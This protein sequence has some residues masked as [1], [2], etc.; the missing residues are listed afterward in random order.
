MVTT[1]Q[2]LNVSE[3]LKKCGVTRLAKESSRFLLEYQSKAVI[4]FTIEDNE[5]FATLQDFEDRSKGRI[6]R[7]TQEAIKFCLSKDEYYVNAL[8]SKANGNAPPRFVIGQ[9]S[10]TTDQ[11]YEENSEQTQTETLS[12]EQA[13]RRNKGR[14]T[15][16]GMIIG[17]SSV[18]QVVTLTE[19]ECSNCKYSFEAKHNPP[20]F[21]LPFSVATTK[22]RKCP[23]CNES[24]YGPHHHEEKS[25]I[26]I[27][28]QD[29]EKQNALESLNVV[30]FEKDTLN[31]RNGEKATVTGDLYVVQ[32]R[33]NSKRITYLFAYGGIQYATPENAQVVVTEEDLA[34]LNDFVKQPDMIDKLKAM[35]AS[36][37][38]GHEDKKLAI[39]LMYIGAPETEDFRGRIH[40]LFIGP[41]G[42]AKSKLARAAK[43]LGEPYSRYSSTQGASGKSITAIIDKE[44]D[45]YVL[46]L[47][48][49]PQARNS[50]CILNEIASLS[51]EDQRHLFD[52]ME[53]GLLTLDKYGFHRE[54]ESPTTVL[55][56]TN[57]E[58]GEWYMD[59]VEKGKIPLRKELVDR[60][61]FL[62]VFKTLKDKDSKTAY[63]KKKLQILRRSRDG[64]AVEDYAFLRKIIEHA[65]TF[66]PQLS[67][68]AEA[69]ITDYWSR[70]DFTVF[71][72]NRVLETIVRVSMAFARLYFSNIVTAEIA[73][74]AMDFITGMFKAFDSTVVLVQDPREATCQEIA[75]FLQ[76]NPNIPYTF[77]D[78]INYAADKNSLIG[79]YL[80]TSPVKND[81]WKY[82][83]IAD[84]F[85]Q[86]LIGEGLVFIEDMNP[87]TLVFKVQLKVSKEEGTARA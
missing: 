45:S 25:A 61:D 72:T 52:V 32:Q 41:P 76:Q 47:G 68:E 81:S 3:D 30:L 37:V 2:E 36:T 74:K 6:D 53:E 31:V 23:N 58:G 8:L 86:G 17:L 60:Y 24:T 1:I 82:R 50:M 49:L 40:G 79:T 56:T 20:L 14:L 9:E 29:E 48:V 34:K 22:T 65:K 13:I 75:N 67:E 5:L 57:P 73:K 46:R 69:M 64:E 27:Q 84:R 44:T 26:I 85:K 28:L 42:T 77:Q 62:L 18:E 63:A 80:G 59:I 39:I 38:I 55:G 71:P 15:V 16:P 4:I 7:Q 43:K 87:L 51:M 78:C 12:V 35:V 54:I 70:L 19:F 21:S 11:H 10:T 33:G 66:N 83:D